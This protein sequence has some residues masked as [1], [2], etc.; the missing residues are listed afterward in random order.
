MSESVKGRSINIQPSD[1]IRILRL[2]D[3]TSYDLVSRSWRLLFDLLCYLKDGAQI[4]SSM[5]TWTKVGDD[6]FI[7]SDGN[8]SLSFN[9]TPETDPDIV[10]QEIADAIAESQNIRLPI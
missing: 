3:D 6:H 2:Q 5:V 7:V 8:K 10:F 4:T 1:L 9:V